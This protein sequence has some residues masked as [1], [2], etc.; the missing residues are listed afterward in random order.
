MLFIYDYKT[1]IHNWR[2]NCRT[3]TYNDSRLA[4]TYAVPFVVPLAFR[5]G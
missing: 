4:R 3:R 1:E 2:P 5:E